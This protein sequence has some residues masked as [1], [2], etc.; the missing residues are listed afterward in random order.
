MA[1]S[2]ESNG[3]SIKATIDK[4]PPDDSVAGIS[5]NFDDERGPEGDHV[6]HAN[7]VESGGVYRAS[8]EYT[9]PLP[10]TYFIVATGLETGTTARLEY[11]ALGNRLGLTV[12]LGT[13]ANWNKAGAT[14]TGLLPNAPAGYASVNFGSGSSIST[15]EASADGTAVIPPDSFTYPDKTGGYTATATATGHISANSSVTLLKPLG[16]A[17]H[18]GTG[19]NWN[20]A[21]ATVTG[22]LP[23]HPGKGSVDFGM[24]IQT[25]LSASDA[26]GKAVIPPNSFTYPDK[27]DTYHA[28]ATSGDHPSGSST[29]TIRKALGLSVQV[30]TGEK[31]NKA[32]ATVTGLVP[33]ATAFVDFGVRN[34]SAVPTP[35]AGADGTAVILA[36]T[37]TYPDDES[38]IYSGCKATAS[39][40]PTA[41][42][43][44]ITRK[45][46]GLSV[47]LRTGF[48]WNVATAT[49]TGLLPLATAVV[50]FGTGQ[51]VTTQ[52]AG[53]NGAAVTP[54]FTYPTTPDTYTATA[55]ADGHRSAETTVTTYWGGVAGAAG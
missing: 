34:T 37:F 52:P 14:V 39:G 10:G 29:V 35:P 54:S 6:R 21:G 36:D 4:V 24:G 51:L 44:A 41:S 32:G 47:Q 9:F 49:V 43:T 20:K 5:V 25:P 42:A 18:L 27:S 16:L 50:D 33:N 31:W 12:N 3:L 28:T 1:V 26:D 13:G 55:T 7:V 53:A 48:Y 22:L 17:V 40:H 19:A 2:L 23:N 15:P 11:K 38:R 30:G 45:A 46:L 8:A